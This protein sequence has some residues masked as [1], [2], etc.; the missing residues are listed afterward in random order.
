MKSVLNAAPPVNK[1]DRE[2]LDGLKRTLR[3]RDRKLK[4]AVLERSKSC[5]NPHQ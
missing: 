2:A 1:R 4:E 3:K 5:A